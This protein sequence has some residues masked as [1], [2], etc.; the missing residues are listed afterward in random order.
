VAL[1]ERTTDALA[2]EVALGTSLLVR[3]V[4]SRATRIERLA[5]V[6]LWMCFRAERG[7]CYNA[8]VVV[9]EFRRSQ[10]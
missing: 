1:E 8:G 6:S 10:A 5:G 9:C 3:R 7:R 2:A 4:G